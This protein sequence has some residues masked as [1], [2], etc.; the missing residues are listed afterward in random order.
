LRTYQREGKNLNPEKKF[1]YEETQIA[2]KY[3]YPE[4]L[5]KRWLEFWGSDFVRE[6]CQSL[7]DRPIFDIRINNQKISIDV[8]KDYLQKENIEYTESRYFKNVCK[9]VD[10][11]KL[12]QTGLLSDGYCTVQDE[13]GLLAVELIQPQPG[14]LI[15]DACAAPGGKYTALIEKYYGSSIITGIEVKWERIQRLKENC[16]RL[17]LPYNW[18]IQGDNRKIPVKPVFD[19][20]LVDAPCSG[21]GTIQKHPDIKWRRTFEEIF[22]FQKL[23]SDMLMN[24]SRQLKP[25]GYLVYS[26]CTVD[27]SENEVVIEQFL[28]GQKGK[29]EYVNPP[30]SLEEF[31]IDAKY[32][33]TFPHQHDMEGSFAVKLHRINK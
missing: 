20:I 1:K 22:E 5:I 4:W 2:V 32:L 8:F 21:F 19:Y 33:K 31:T 28:N 18:L 14:D 10:I 3:S 11:Q 12:R 13:S 9:I 24:I 23:Q 30:A 27:P 29:F 16:R 25:D 17:D 7:N 26:T 15:L 6:M